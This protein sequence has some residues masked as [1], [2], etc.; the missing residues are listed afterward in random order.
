ME[1]PP[2]GFLFSLFGRKGEGQAAAPQE[3]LGV[4]KEA[5]GRVKESAELERVDVHA[6]ARQCLE[7]LRASARPV[8]RMGELPVR[9]AATALVLSDELVCN[10]RLMLL[11]FHPIFLSPPAMLLCPS[12][13]GSLLSPIISS[14]V[15][16]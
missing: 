3:V 11:L 1:S 13:V 10:D 5:H 15:L 14:I 12:F 6:D 4:G 9:P 8:A 16:Q 7:A 2:L